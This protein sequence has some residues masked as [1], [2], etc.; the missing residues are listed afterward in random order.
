MNY[1]VLY[2]SIYMFSILFG[3]VQALSQFIPQGLIIFSSGLISGLR[4]DLKVKNFRNSNLLGLAEVNGL[5]VRSQCR[6]VVLNHRA[7]GRQ[8]GDFVVFVGTGLLFLC[9]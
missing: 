9:S 3:C 7:D 6:F 2:I 8:A 4:N 5:Q 1:S